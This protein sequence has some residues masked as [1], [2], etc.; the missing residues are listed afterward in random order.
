MNQIL[1]AWLV[2]V[3]LRAVRH[4]GGH[5]FGALVDQRADVSVEWPPVEVALDKVLLNFRAQR[6]QQKPH[7][8]EDRIVAQDGM[9][10]LNQV[11][12]AH[13]G[14]NGHHRCEDP[15][16]RRSRDR[17]DHRCRS[18]SDQQRDTCESNQW[19]NSVSPG[20]GGWLIS[21]Y[22]IPGES[23]VTRTPVH[24]TATAR[25]PAWWSSGTPPGRRA[26][27]R[28]WSC[29]VRCRCSRRGRT[30]AVAA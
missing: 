14:E 13:H 27:G 12:N 2:D 26:T 5:A 15:P 28:A 19:T 17:Q 10:A 4:F 21:P 30:A 24:K 25:C 22:Y 18:G 20:R 16:A 1:I 9:L 6:L 11:V 23:T 8:P 3:T 7:M 29:P